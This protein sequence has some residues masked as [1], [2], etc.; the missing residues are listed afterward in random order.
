MIRIAYAALAAVALLSLA[1]VPAR[2]DDSNICDV[3]LWRTDAAGGQA[4][5]DACT[6]L[7]ESGR[8]SGNYREG[9]FNNRGNA[10]SDLG[11]YARA[12]QDYDEAIRLNPNDDKA[13][14]NRGGAYY[15]LRQYARAI[16]DYDEAIRLTND[17][18]AFSN[19]G[20]AYGNL[21]QYARAIR[22][23]DEAIRLKPNDAYAFYDRAGAYYGLGQYA[24]AIKD[25]DEAIRL[26]DDGYAFYGRGIAQRAKGNTAAAKNSW[27]QASA[28]DHYVVFFDFQIENLTEAASEVVK[29]MADSYHAHDGARIDL[30][31]HTDTAEADPQQWA[32][33]CKGESKE[34]S[35]YYNPIC[36]SR[37]PNPQGL[38]LM[39]AQAVAN[40]LV[41]I[42]IPRKVIDVK[43]VG[44]ADPLV[45]TGPATREPENRRVTAWIE[46]RP[47]TS[48]A[49]WAQHLVQSS[50]TGGVPVGGPFNRLKLA[51]VAENP[52]KAVGDPVHGFL[53][54]TKSWLIERDLTSAEDI[55][56]LAATP[57]TDEQMGSLEIDLTDDAGK[58]MLADSER[59]S[60]GLLG[61][62]IALVLNGQTVLVVAT[63]QTPIGKETSV[64][65]GD[66]TPVQ[67]K[68]LVAAAG[69]VETSGPLADL[70]NALGW[71]F[72]FVVALL[73][74]A[75]GGA[76][77]FLM[78]RRRA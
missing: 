7:I 42:G 35:P 59:I 22:D 25:Y 5:I 36:R 33:G 54:P 74:V 72:V 23:Y 71:E 38:G 64:D 32:Q 51:L 55:Q 41:R 44:A 4:K 31:G 21:G 69:A 12:I 9:A 78:L 47:T 11:Q 27:P 13:F 2:A 30:I 53:D 37:E 28:R 46:S 61:R 52:A 62:Q 15:G 16:Q 24:R 14:Y 10:Y 60:G 75:V 50:P 43:S 45:P 56:Y 58:R 17:A 39:R 18:Y 68:H 70:W 73:A 40:E 19:R 67:F 6:R 8:L 66:I 57:A 34:D 29:A 20:N 65:L 77:R 49:I 63:V 48:A 76:V 3:P 26:T 1:G